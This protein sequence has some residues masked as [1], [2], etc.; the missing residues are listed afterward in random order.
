[1]DQA[2]AAH[3]GTIAHL[4]SQTTTARGHRFARAPLHALLLAWHPGFALPKANMSHVSVQPDIFVRTTQPCS[5]VLRALI[6]RLDAT[7]LANVLSYHIALKDRA[8]RG[9][10]ALF[11]L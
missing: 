1:M 6:A 4:S 8:K 2:R 5:S 11:S 9:S 10:M 3:W 7:S